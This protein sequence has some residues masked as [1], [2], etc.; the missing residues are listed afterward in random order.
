[1]LIPRVLIGLVL[2]VNIQCAGAFVLHPVAYMGGFGLE[3]IVGE[4]MV[5]AMGVLFLMWNVPYAF[6]LVHPRKYRSSL[7]EALIMQTIGLVGETAILLLGGPYPSPVELTITRFIIFDGIGLGL[8]AAALSL[9]QI[10]KQSQPTEQPE[11]EH[12]NANGPQG[13]FGAPGDE[14]GNQT[15]QEA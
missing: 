2:L 5:R 14:D 3:G 4:Q 12:T 7:I 8:L 1:M 15:C 13:A 9:V 6:A 11:R 10:D